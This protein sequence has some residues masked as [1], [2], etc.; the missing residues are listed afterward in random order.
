VQ[1]LLVEVDAGLSDRLLD[2]VAV[3]GRVHDDLHDRSPQPQ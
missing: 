2:A 3:A 1:L